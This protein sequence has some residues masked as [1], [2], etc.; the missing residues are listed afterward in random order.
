M[1]GPNFRNKV[2]VL[3]SFLGLL[4]AATEAQ[5]VSTPQESKP[6]AAQGGRNSQEPTASA[7]ASSSARKA[8]EQPKPIPPDKV[9]L[10]VGDDKATAGDFYHMMGATEEQAQKVGSQVRRTLEGQYATMLLL[11][12]QAIRDR[13]DSTAEFAKQLTLQRNQLL[14][15]LEY[16]KLVDGVRVSQEDISQYYSSH[17]DE[18]EQAELRRVYVRKKP[19]GAKSD[20]LGLSPLEAKAKAEAISKEWVS[21]KDLK[22]VETEFKDSKIY[23]DEHAERVSLKQLPE[24]LQKTVMKLKPGGVSEP[25]E[26][27]QGFL[28]LQLVKLSHPE[29]KD[30]STQM[31][32]KLRKEKID[33][34]MEELKRK[35]S[36]WMDDE[37]FSYNPPSPP[38]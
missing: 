3:F 4:T 21:G 17:Q 32:E 1:P 2:L 28:V 37:Y 20:A 14:A 33:A 10:T 27:P 22:E 24:E 19:E 8:A 18:F 7:V 29:L 26:G 38:H 31:G 34:A 23:F 35:D 9:V 5:Q 36:I 25:I 16:K 30:I 6:A 12:H 15:Q 11:A 13:L